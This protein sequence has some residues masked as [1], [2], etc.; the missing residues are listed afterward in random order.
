MECASIFQMR[1][2]FRDVRYSLR[3][4]TKS[5]GFTAVA[6]VTLALGLGASTAIFSVLDAVLLR[7]LPYPKP[8]QVVRIWEQSANGHRLSFADLNFVDIKAQ[9]HTLLHVAEY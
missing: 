5:R 4:L 1:N 2:V 9:N 3:T 6:V 8:D 7:P